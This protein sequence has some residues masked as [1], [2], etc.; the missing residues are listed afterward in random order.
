MIFL[1][2]MKLLSLSSWISIIYKYGLIGYR[3]RARACG[4]LL[5]ARNTGCRV[6]PQDFRSDKQAAACAHTKD[7]GAYH[8]GAGSRSQP[9]SHA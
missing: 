6:C 3:G 9:R 7:R 1:I 4:L 8:C 2:F 5:L